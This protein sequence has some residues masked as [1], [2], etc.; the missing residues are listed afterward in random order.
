MIR[1]LSFISHFS[2]KKVSNCLENHPSPCIRVVL[3]VPAASISGLVAHIQGAGGGQPRDGHGMA[4]AHR[5]RLVEIRGALTGPNFDP[6]L[7][8]LTGMAGGKGDRGTR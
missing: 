1:V 5:P 8:V 3:F 6:M 7:E 2:L 4:R